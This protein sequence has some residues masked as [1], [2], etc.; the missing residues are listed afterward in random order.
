M[1][2]HRRTGAAQYIQETYGIP[3]STGVLANLAC[4]GAG[5]R[6]SKIGKYPIYDT[7]DLDA[8]IAQRSTPKVRSTSEYSGVA[9]AA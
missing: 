1:A 8:W 5:P 2:K 7:T 4:R 3:C 6:Y 9:A